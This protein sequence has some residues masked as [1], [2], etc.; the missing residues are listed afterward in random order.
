MVDPRVIH[1]IT[2][3]MC[4]GFLILAGT[5]VF[6]KVAS[7]WWLRHLRGRQARL[8]RWALA[9]SR[10]AEPAS[11][12]ALIAGVIAT[13]I[14]MVTGMLAWPVDQLW[15][16]ETVH[17]KILVTSVSQTMFIG[18]VILRARYRFEIWM[19]RGTGSFYALLIL[20]GDALMTLQN[21]IAGHLAG[22][23]SL[24]DDVLHSV[25]ID[26]HPM[27]TFPVWASVLIAILFPVAAVI[28]GLRLRATAAKQRPR[29]AAA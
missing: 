19:T 12:F 6:V 10:F 4:T 14:S 17:N 2:I 26:T 11:Y 29:A 25:G 23:G 24:L 9:A 28:I 13:F 5:A 15:A 21:S 18:A 3:E 8:D 7:D 1:S 22:K 16:S 20:S 27:W